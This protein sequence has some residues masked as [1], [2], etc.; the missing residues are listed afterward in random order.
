[1][2]HYNDYLYHHGVKG[3]KWGVRKDKYKAMSRAEK[4][5]TKKTYKDQKKFEKNVSKNWT[6]SY[7]KA[8]NIMN[9]KIEGINKKY[10]DADLNRDKPRKIDRDYV[11]AMNKAWTETYSKVLLKDFGT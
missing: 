1:M 5:K 6:T 2:E 9:E 4:K 7:N 8:A 10:K 3:M 11:N